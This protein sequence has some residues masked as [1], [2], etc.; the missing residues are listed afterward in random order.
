MSC[1]K[2]GISDVTDWHQVLFD[3]FLNASQGETMRKKIYLFACFLLFSR[4]GIVP[5]VTFG[6]LLRLFLCGPCYP[7]D[8]RMGA[9]GWFFI[10]PGSSC[11]GGH[12]VR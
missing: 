9:C 5:I 8:T 1:L 7:S 12:K 11:W 4:F 3:D 2:I 10:S 6:G